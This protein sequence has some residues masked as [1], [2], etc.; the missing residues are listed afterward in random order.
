MKINKQW[1]RCAGIRAVRTMA[2]VAAA[3]LVI[4]NTEILDINWISLLSVVLL[5]GV[6]CVIMGLAGLPEAKEEKR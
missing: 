6:A 4:D 2:Q 5:S 3:Q 1:W